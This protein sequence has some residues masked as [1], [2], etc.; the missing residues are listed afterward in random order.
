MAEAA[1]A[2]CEGAAAVLLR[3]RAAATGKQQVVDAAGALLRLGPDDGGAQAPELLRAGQAALADAAALRSEYLQA[4]RAV[5]TA[6]RD[7]EAKLRGTD[8]RIAA[9]RLQ[10]DELEADLARAA[11]RQPPPAPATID[12]RTVR[13]CQRVA[14]GWLGRRRA[15][16][17]A[18]AVASGDPALL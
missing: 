9:V 3:P 6:N 12:D 8:A 14:R 13:E 10:N 15:L 2:P 17:V 7:M 5:L 4:L 1:G 11:G 18:V 16:A